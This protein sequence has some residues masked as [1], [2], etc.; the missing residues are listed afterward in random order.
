MARTKTIE[1]ILE[2]M[3]GPSRVVRYPGQGQGIT[4]TAGI[5]LPYALPSQQG[6]EPPL[7]EEEVRAIEARY[8]QQGRGMGEPPLTEEEVRTRAAR[9]MVGTPPAAPPAAPPPAP[10]PAPAVSGDGS[11]RPGIGARI[12]SGIKGAAHELLS[13]IAM[14]PERYQE[15]QQ[16]KAMLPGKLALASDVRAQDMADFEKKWDYQ[17]KNP[18]IT[19]GKELSD[20]D[21]IQLQKLL[22][23]ITTQQ[24]NITFRLGSKEAMLLSPEDKKTLMDSVKELEL[25]R[26]QVLKALIESPVASASPA[27]TGGVPG[28]VS[29][30]APA[31]S[32]AIQADIDKLRKAGKPEADIKEFI[33]HKYGVSY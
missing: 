10:A 17:I 15:V 8:P 1:E 19:V 30:V 20:A 26:Q 28:A 21:K 7:T 14:G 5:K 25:Q 16:E 31:P 24:N 18:K 29:A 9:S 27:A 11:S 13:G 6:G 22:V 3:Y 33:R 12:G 4:G 32:P 23:E 2:E